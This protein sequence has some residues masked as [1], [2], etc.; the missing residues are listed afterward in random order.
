MPSL[1]EFQC[2][3]ATALRRDPI[4]D[5]S[6]AA[7][8]DGL[9]IHRNTLMKGLVDAILA[10]YPTVS[11]LMG[12]EW[13]GHAAQAYA[14]QHPARQ[15]MLATY[16]EAFPEFLGDLAEDDAWPYLCAV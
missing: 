14:R 1:A 13:T 2:E 12:A 5:A 3:F 9:R 8:P 11:V 7:E 15:A 6:C 10:N 4:G 16:G